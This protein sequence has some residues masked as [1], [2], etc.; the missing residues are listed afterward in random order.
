MSKGL[1]NLGN[2]C[3]MNSALQCLLHLPQ[4]SSDNE[5]L[6]VDCTKR[7]V[8]TDYQLMK[9]WL[10]LYQDMWT[11]DGDTFSNTKPI[12]NEFRKRCIKESRNGRRGQR[13]RTIATNS[14]YH[15]K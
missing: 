12:L 13:S 9:E 3:Y 10:R 1:T 15:T 5:S 8:K 2:T 11:E 7:S 4:I 6:T 14:G